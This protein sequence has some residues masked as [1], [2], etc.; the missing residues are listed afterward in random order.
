[1]EPS[2]FVLIVAVFLAVAVVAAYLLVV[3]AILSN[4]NRRLRLVLSGVDA[5]TEKATPVGPIIE[6]INR[7]LATGRAALEGCVERLKERQVPP[8]PPEPRRFP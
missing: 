7:D 6:E 4:V 8:P 1:M 5:V 2:A 3:I